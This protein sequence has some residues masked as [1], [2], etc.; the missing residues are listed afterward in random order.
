MQSRK[1]RHNPSEDATPSSPQSPNS[2]RTVRRRFCGRN[3]SIRSQSD[4]QND[5]LEDNLTPEDVHDILQCEADDVP[6]PEEADCMQ[7]TS[8][9]RN[10]ANLA[11]AISSPVRSMSCTARGSSNALELSSSFPRLR[12]SKSTG[13]RHK[14]Q[15]VPSTVDDRGADHAANAVDAQVSSSL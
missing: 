2:F 12:I 10:K 13:G 4:A 5:G 11:A 14:Q 3:V 15:T 8:L 9:Q 1:E 7:K 6:Q